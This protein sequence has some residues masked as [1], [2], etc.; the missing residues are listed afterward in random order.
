MCKT[1]LKADLKL[2]WPSI[3]IV[4]P[5]TLDIV[6]IDR[7]ST[8]LS[9]LL[10]SN[11]FS[12]FGPSIASGIQVQVDNPFLVYKIFTGFTYVLGGLI[13]L[14]LKIKMTKG[15]WTRIW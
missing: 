8:A 7:F 1:Y 9:M 12:V 10:M 3:S 6:G 5:I 15:L 4:S 13:L 2:T 11:I 14:A